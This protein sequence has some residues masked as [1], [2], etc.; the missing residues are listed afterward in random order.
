[1]MKTGEMG[2]IHTAGID[3][4][5][6]HRFLDARILDDIRLQFDVQTAF[7]PIQQYQDFRERG[8]AGVPGRPNPSRYQNHRS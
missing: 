5:L 4:K 3:H 6:Q 1:M 2:P 8:N 7:P